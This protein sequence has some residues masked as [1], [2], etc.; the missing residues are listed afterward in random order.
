M[1]IS[2]FYNGQYHLTHYKKPTSSN[3]LPNFHSETPT[4]YK[5]SSLIGSIY[6]INDT[7]SNDNELKK[8]L[9]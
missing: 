3:V 5:I 7:T 6:R 8:S 2:I 1:D 4:T 9:N